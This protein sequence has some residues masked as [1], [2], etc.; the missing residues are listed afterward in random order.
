[1][2]SKNKEKQNKIR[3]SIFDPD[4]PIWRFLAGFMDCVYLSVLWLVCSLPVVT[5]GASTTALYSTAYHCLRQRDD[6]II[7]RFF[8]TF[9]SEF[10]Q[11]TLSWLLWA[12]VLGLYCVLWIFIFTLGD[13]S[14]AWLLMVSAFA[15]TFVA[16]GALRWVFPALAR[17]EFTLKELNYNAVKLVFARPVITVLLIIILL[18][19]AAACYTWMFPLL[20]LPGL[21]ARLDC[22]LIEGPGGE[23]KPEKEESV[24][25]KQS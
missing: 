4:R 15:V 3:Q 14:I 24:D 5:I 18:L 22:L 10:R 23:N 1:M 2:M 13:S 17:Y 9:R 7:H 20:V 21:A 8:S 19:S 16:L 11:A 12:A 6:T 25:G